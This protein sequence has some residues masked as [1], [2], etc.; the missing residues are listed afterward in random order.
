MSD[1]ETL[2]NAAFERRDVLT[3]SEI[4]DQ[5]R[6]ALEQ[7][8]DLLESGARR[9]AEPDGHGGWAVHAWLKK[10]VLLYFRINDSRVVDGGAALA[11]DKV[12]LRFMHGHDTELQE[13]GARVVPGALVRRGVHIARDAVLMP[14]YV[15]IGAFVGAGSMVDTW[16][17]VG[18]CAQIGA[19]VH[20]SGGVG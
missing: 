17:T 12:P 13:L 16:A 20:L 8:L 2:I 18:S 14:S 1:L 11:F 5:L 6:P 3:A 4:E 15:N 9:V 7:V 10:A 19:G